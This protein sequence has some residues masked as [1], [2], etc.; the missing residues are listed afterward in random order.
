MVGTGPNEIEE[1]VGLTAIL[2]RLDRISSQI[3]G[4][5]GIN[6]PMGCRFTADSEGM[7]L[8]LSELRRRGLI[9]VDSVTTSD[10]KGYSTAAALGMPYAVRDVFLD[11][12]ID[13]DAIRK[14]LSLIPI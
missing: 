11:N 10:S 7:R 4:Y 14:Q 6:N 3:F 12:T 5:V 13:T 2:R 9:F 8:V 1:E